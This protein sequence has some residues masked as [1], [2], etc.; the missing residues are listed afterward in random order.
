MIHMNAIIFPGQGSQKVGMARA[1]FE[2]SASCRALF[3]QADEILGYDLG[4][5]CFDGPEERLTNTFYAQPALLTVGVA[6]WNSARENGLT[7]NMTAGH[8]LG[9]YAALVAANVLSFQAAMTL[10]KRRAE[11]MANAPSG[12]MAAIIGLPDDAINRVLDI[13]Q[14]SGIV[15]AA[16]YNSPGQIVVSGEE[17][18]VESAMREA[19]T[20]GAKMAVRLPVSGAFHSPLMRAAGA[21]M[22]TLIDAA[23]FQNADF[24][25]Y[26][27]TTARA[28]TEADE[29]RSALTKQMTSTV[30]WTETVRAMIA[31]G[32]TSFYELGAGKVLVGLVKRIDKSVAVESSET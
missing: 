6:A 14:G 22:K 32:A 26:P 25:V 1:L 20:C 3:A 19:K 16:N 10:V 30:R 13:A 12:T 4:A 21:E 23:P 8:S 27:N 5:L 2:S 17:A 7:A 15:V 24:A 31:D 28:T 29:L 11:L 18:A 9:E